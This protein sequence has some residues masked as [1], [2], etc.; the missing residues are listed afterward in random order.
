MPS[1][2]SS[3]RISAN[4]K[5]T[6][7]IGFCRPVKTFA[8]LIGVA[9]G[10]VIDDNFTERIRSMVAAP[11]VRAWAATPLAAGTGTAWVRLADMNSSFAEDGRTDGMHKFK[12]Y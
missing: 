1:W 12:R 2:P 3:V 10:K 11:A 4:R 7:V 6:S 9:N 8:S 5:A